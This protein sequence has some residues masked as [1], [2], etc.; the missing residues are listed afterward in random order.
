[1]KRS[2]LT[3]AAGLMTGMLFTGLHVSAQTNA[4]TLADKVSAIQE[5]ITGFEDRL[6]TDEGDLSKLTKIKFSGYIQS[7]YLRY[8]NP[9]N[10][11]YNTFMIRRARV[12][13]TYEPASGVAFTLEPDYQPNNFTLKNAY[14]QLNDPWL[15]TFSLWAGKFDRPDYEVEYSSSNLEDLERSKVITSLYPDEKAIGVKLE[16]APPRIPL[17]IQIAGLNGNEGLTYSDAAGNVI[18]APQQNGDFDKYK[19]LM[20]RVTY[21][22]K[23]GNFGALNIGAHV[24]YGKVKANSYDVLNSD[25]TYN[26]S[27]SNPGN[28]VKRNWVGFEAQ[29]YMDVLGGLALKGEYL[30]GVN[31]T[32]GYYSTTSTTSQSVSSS[33]DTLFVR[34]ITTTAVS[35]KP[36][37]EKNFMGY[38][39]YLIKNIGKRHQLAVRYD[40]Y[41]PDTKISGKQI[42]TNKYAANTTNITDHYDYSGSANGNV[43]AT[44]SR[45]IKTVTNS[46]SSGTGDV[47]YGTWTMAYSY[48]FTDNI[49]VQLAYSVPLNEKAGKVDDNGNGN[50]ISKYNV[51]NIAGVLDYSKVFPQNTL[52]L[53]LQVKF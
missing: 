44:D 14:V 52:T 48:Y 45:T 16:I 49:K 25:Y 19:D 34:N 20:A 15:K 37:I 26:K 17:K 11:P 21:G 36:A 18:N 39:V 12:K 5:K 47:A 10:Y 40:Y 1:M 30:V 6:T 3:I 9:S 24:Y 2:I 51:N 35:A 38:Y 7:Q 31:G 33:N 27:I 22:F 29:L 23:L 41:D 46:L 53:R 8:E 43:I 4:D 28:S 32:P 42:G 13:L 50:V